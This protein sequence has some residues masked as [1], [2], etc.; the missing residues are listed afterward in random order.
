MKTI[1]NR[2]RDRLPSVLLT[3]LSIVQALALEFLWSHISEAEYP[4]E[5]SWIAAISWLQIAASFNGI[6]L[7]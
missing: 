7:I 4:F 1:R 5:P 3:L 6:V 2:A